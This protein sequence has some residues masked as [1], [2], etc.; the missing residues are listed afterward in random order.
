MRGL[1]HPDAP[2]TARLVPQNSI[3]E[4][5]TPDPSSRI[6]VANPLQRLRGR[7]D[8][9]TP[10]LT[11]SLETL[12]SRTAQASAKWCP[13]S[14]SGQRGA[15]RTRGVSRLVCICHPIDPFSRR[16]RTYELFVTT[17]NYYKFNNYVCLTLFDYWTFMI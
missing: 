12:T 9:V 6:R 11:R 13:T 10:D 5:P 4:K 15:G 16:H 14:P 1:P 17:C 8:R 2:F 7:T 3:G